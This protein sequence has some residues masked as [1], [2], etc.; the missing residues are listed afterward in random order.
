MRSRKEGAVEGRGKWVSLCEA[1]GGSVEG[2]DVDE[3][4]K[5]SIDNLRTM[6]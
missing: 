4:T 5:A 6:K 1:G 3:D 2:M